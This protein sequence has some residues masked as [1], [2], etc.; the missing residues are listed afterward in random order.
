[1][2]FFISYLLVFISLVGTAISGYIDLKTTE[3]PDEIPL[4]MVIIGLLIRFGFSLFTG[5]WR[6]LFFP[7]LIGAGFFLFGIIM[8]FT[9]QWGGGDAKVLGAVGILIGTLPE[10]I[11]SYS[12][13][14][15]FLNIFFNVFLVGAAY[16]IVY[17]LLISV[18]NKKI[19]KYFLK[20]LKA[21]KIEFLVFVSAILI[22][23]G[24]NV[25]IFWSNFGI[26]FLWPSIGAFF[27]CMGLYFLW[28]FLKTVEKVG[29]Y[30]KIKTE[31]LREGDMIGED[32]K[33]LD[34]NKRIIRGLTKEEVDKIRKIKDKI[35]VREGVRFAP[36]FFITIVV[37]ILFGNLLMLVL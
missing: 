19:K 8:Y 30:K 37:T 32:V 22:I 29:F 1:M 25:F 2:Q 12:I 28:K 13:F 27:G 21:G 20:S 5:D 16:I 33:E 15:F 23:L 9:G 6:F 34:L 24:L 4:A 18:R 10:G 7:A 17:A 26:V 3:I 31:K 14:P 36:V 35:W 11:V